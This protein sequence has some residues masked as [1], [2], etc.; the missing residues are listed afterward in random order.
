MED[1]TG[2]EEEIRFWEKFVQTDRFLKD[3]CSNEVTSELLSGQHEVVN[4]IQD[5][6]AHNP[7]LEVLDVGSGVVSILTGLVPKENLTACDLLAEDYIKI[8]DY[9]K[10][11][12]HWPSS[13][14]V[15]LIQSEE[16]F[17]IVH[18]RNA[19]DHSQDPMKGVHNLIKSLRKGGLLII[20]GFT[21]EAIAENWKG[22]HQWNIDLEV[23]KG[24]ERLHNMFIKDKDGV[25]FG[26]TA[27]Y[28]SKKKILDT[29]KEWF[30]WI[31]QK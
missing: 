11:G 30:I 29:G 13:I 21:N 1:K 31:L 4:I 12:L 7:E 22:M 27:N 28:F 14:P 2:K 18:M 8:F 6:L 16:S 26:F 20:H 9:A 17:D 15:E 23:S 10:H 5:F 19:L 25:E 24:D 3:W